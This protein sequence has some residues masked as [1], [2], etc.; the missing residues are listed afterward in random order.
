[1]SVFDTLSSTWDVPM[2]VVTT[3]ATDDGPAG[4]LVGFWSQCSIDPPRCALFLSEQNHTFRVARHADVLVAHVLHAGDFALAK[5]F[6]ALTGDRVDKFAD[7]DWHAGPD[8]APVL[9]GLDWFA[10]RILDT[11]VSGDHV[12]FIMEV[13]DG[14]GAADRAG[15]PLLRMSEVQEIPAGH[16]A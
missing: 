2:L 15:E 12:A 1:M 5:R 10:G 9:D 11:Q 13:L 6:G 7:V 4:C 8:G 14:E 16:D 3:S